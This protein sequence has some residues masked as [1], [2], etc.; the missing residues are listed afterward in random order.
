MDSSAYERGEFSSRHSRLGHSHYMQSPVVKKYLSCLC[1][2]SLKPLADLQRP[3][4]I[5][6]VV[7]RSH[8]TLPSVC[9]RG[10]N[11]LHRHSIVCGSQSDYYKVDRARRR[12]KDVALNLS[13]QVLR[14]SS[15]SQVSGLLRYRPSSHPWP[16]TQAHFKR[17]NVRGGGLKQLGNVDE[18]RKQLAAESCLDD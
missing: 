16:Q 12:I 18:L 15:Q 8:L 5:A 10:H 9:L 2:N 3:S 7:C 4:S 14:S 17:Q 11:L 13:K 1:L 6:F